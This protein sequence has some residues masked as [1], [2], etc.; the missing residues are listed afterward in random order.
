MK[1]KTNY[2][3]AFLMITVSWAGLVSV[4]QADWSIGLRADNDSQES[5]RNKKH[6]YSVAILHPKYRG[7]KFN[8]D[9]GTASYDFTNSNNFAV[10]AILKQNHYGFESS[11]GST[12]KGMKKRKQSIDVG[13]RGILDTGL[14]GPA[15]VEITRDF[16]ASK[17]YEANAKIGGI[18]PHAP[19]WTGERKVQIAAM[20]GLRYQSAKTVDYYY[21]VKSSEATANRKQYKAKSALTPYIGVEGQ[22]NLTPHISFDG[23]LT[24][25]KRANSIRKS[26]L[27]NNKKYDYGVN[28]GFSYWF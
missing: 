4:A 14:V 22:V 8:I 10:E 25:S 7:D 16:H 17:G 27:S 12:F 19:H 11:D 18:T 9:N 23:G 20:G 24:L 2:A 21:G 28:V 13:A 26:P 6:K 5:Y 15:V 3:S 1:N